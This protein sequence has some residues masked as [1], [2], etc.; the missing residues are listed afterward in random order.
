MPTPKKQ[1][2]KT[3]SKAGQKPTTD[4]NKKPVAKKK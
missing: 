4:K 3:E 2:K 1:E